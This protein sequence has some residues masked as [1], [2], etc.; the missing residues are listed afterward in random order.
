MSL[1]QIIDA[2]TFYGIDV[3]VLAAATALITQVIKLTLFRRAQKKTV[4]FLPFLIGALLYAAYAAVRNLSVIYVIENYIDVLEHG[5]SVGATA[6]LYYV[7]Y[8]Q[9]VREKDGLS[10]TEKVITTLIE[11]Y[12]PDENV[13]LA[14]KA[15]AEAIERDVTGNGA[16]R[17]EQILAEYSG[18]Q[19][20]EKDVKLLARLI[21][22]TLAHLSTK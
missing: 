8:E 6:T 7:M 17:A 5:V 1:I 11:G 4:T 15:V 22:E 14:A 10:T 16:V 20:S 12:V 3:I 9:F 13:E 18:G 19:A 21:I 2:F